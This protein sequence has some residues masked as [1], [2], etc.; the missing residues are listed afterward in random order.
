MIFRWSLWG[1]NPKNIEMLFYSISSF[2]TFFGTDHEYIVYTDNEKNIDESINKIAAVR[3]FPADCIFNIKSKPT[4]MK[5][6][7]GPRLDPHTTEFYVDMDVFLV[8]YPTE[9]MDFLHNDQYKFAILDE[10]KGEPW[11]HGSMQRKD[12]EH[13]P[14]VNAG[15]FV[16]KAGYDITDDFVDEYKWW[17]H[18]IP[19]DEHTHFDEQGALALALERYVQNDEVCILPKDK[20]SL[21]SKELNTHIQTLEQITLFHSMGSDREAFYRFLPELRTVT[22]Q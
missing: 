10:V 15:L 13:T 22:Q 21:F 16:Q 14:Y 1:N 17:Q 11:Q 5:W 19:V 2:R 9:I 4:W 7:A 8:K 6:C 3:I 20:Y 12:T 18:N